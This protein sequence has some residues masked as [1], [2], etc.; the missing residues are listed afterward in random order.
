[1]K[2]K[3][4][5]KELTLVGMGAALMAVFSQIAIPLP[6][7]VPV[8][9]QAFAVVIIAIV[10]EQ[11]LAV[12]AL[13]IFTLVGSIGVPVFANF[14][15][16]IRVVIGPTGGY[17]IGFII[18]GFIIGAASKTNNKWIIFAS[19][20]A[21]LI[22]DY[23]IGVTQLA[24]VAKLSLAQALAGGMYPFVIKDVIAVGLAAVVA[25][26]IKRIVRKEL[27]KSAVS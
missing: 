12:L 16:G 19:V 26:Q 5:I 1:M 18:M 15:G 14:N 24:L 25:L 7:G 27:V 6:I 8:T 23:I 10:L 21:G 2:N 4:S 20:Y 9:L 17:L 3:L 11:K 22:V 13:F